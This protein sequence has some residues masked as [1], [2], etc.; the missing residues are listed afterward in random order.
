M[1]LVNMFSLKLGA[2]TLYMSIENE[3]NMTIND[4][5]TNKIKK[6]ATKSGQKTGLNTGVPCGVPLSKGTG[7]RGAP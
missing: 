6:K 4:R 5:R 2:Y 1:I 3:K 7:G